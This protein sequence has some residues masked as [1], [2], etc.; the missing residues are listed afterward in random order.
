MSVV[1]P[2]SVVAPPERIAPDAAHLDVK[3]PA[4]AQVYVNGSPTKLTGEQRRFISSGLAA[5][6]TYTYSIEARLA[7]GPETLT[8]MQ[9]VTVSAGQSV[10]VMFDFTSADTQSAA[11]RTSLLLNVPEDA[12]VFLNGH[13]TTSKGPARIFAT[14]ALPAGDRYADYEIKAEIERN[15]QKIVREQKVSLVAG[16]SHELTIDFATPS[17]NALSTR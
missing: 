13:P 16:K 15:G 12:Q 8:R 4:D 17:A 9:T 2:T 7:R 14:T 5:D 6:K 3:V 11:V 1:R 10:P